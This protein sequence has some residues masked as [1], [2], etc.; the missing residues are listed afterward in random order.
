M[1]LDLRKPDLRNAVAVAVPPADGLIE[2]FTVGRDA[3]LAQVRRGATIG[4]RRYIDGDT[5][6]AD[7]KLPFPGAAK[8]AADPAHAHADFIYT[9]GGWTQP[10]RGFVL[11]GKGTRPLHGF[12]VTA[13]NSL[14]PVVEKVVDS[15][16]ADFNNDGR[17]DMFLLSGVQLRPASVVKGDDRHIEAH[18]KLFLHLVRGDGFELLVNAG[19]GL[20]QT[21]AG[22]DTL[23]A[24]LGAKQ[25]RGEH[26][27][28]PRGAGRYHGRAGRFQP[29]AANRVCVNLKCGGTLP[30]P[31]CVFP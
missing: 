3:V 6:G 10:G 17:L 19:P 31:I 23:R 12:D 29:A 8:V 16:L 30:P 11:D 20:L 22:L 15:V 4:L 14:F 5:A 13:P 18:R 27:V 9:L 26:Q 1:K 25:I 2:G 28:I 7:V 21:T 24:V